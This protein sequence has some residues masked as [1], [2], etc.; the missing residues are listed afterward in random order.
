MNIDGLESFLKTEL[1]YSIDQQSVLEQIGGVEID[2][3]DDTETETVSTIIGAV[4][5]QTYDSADELFQT[6]VG[7][8]SD[9]YIGRKFYDDRGANPADTEMGPRDEINI[10][11]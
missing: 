3:P 7:N 8:L 5:Q 6:I 11:F 10:S 4:G 1:A 2:A 9:E